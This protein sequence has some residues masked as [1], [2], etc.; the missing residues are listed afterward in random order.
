MDTLAVVK[1]FL[2]KR[3]GASVQEAPNYLRQ[4][5]TMVNRPNE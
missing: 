2:Y 3:L 4:Y 5:V 1:S